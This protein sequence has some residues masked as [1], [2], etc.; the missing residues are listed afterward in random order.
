MLS[1]VGPALQLDGG[2]RPR[3]AS[4]YTMSQRLRTLLIRFIA[5]FRRYPGYGGKRGWR[6]LRRRYA[7]GSLRLGPLRPRHG[8]GRG[9][10]RRVNRRR[11]AFVG[12]TMAQPPSEPST[13]DAGAQ[14]EGPP[15]LYRAMNTPEVPGG[16]TPELRGT[17]ELDGSDAPQGPGRWRPRPDRHRMRGRDGIREKRSRSFKP[18]R[19]HPYYDHD[20]A[21]LDQMRVHR[22]YADP[23]PSIPEDLYGQPEDMKPTIKTEGKQE[24]TAPAFAPATRVPDPLPPAAD[25]DAPATQA[26]N[27]QMDAPGNKAPESQPAMLPLESVP[28]PRTSEIPADLAMPQDTPQPATTPD[29]P[30]G[31]ASTPRSSD[32]PRSLTP[33]RGASV[34]A[35]APPSSAP[36]TSSPL[37]EGLKTPLPASS[38]SIEVPVSDLSS[39]PPSHSAEHESANVMIS[40]HESLAKSADTASEERDDELRKATQALAQQMLLRYPLSEQH[41]Q[42]LKQ[43]NQAIVHS[44]SVPASLAETKAAAPPIQADPTT[45]HTLIHAQIQA[46]ER[47]YETKLQALRTEYR[48]KHQAWTEYCHKLDQMYERRVQRNSMSASD[49]A[50]MS[51]SLSSVLG[52]PVSSRSFRRGGI[53]AGGF[54][55][56]VRSEAEFQEIL[57]SLEN[58]EMQDPAVRAARTSATVPDMDLR[59]P[60][61]LDNDNGYVADP[62]R[63][64]FHSFDPDV[65]SE[66]EKAIF[67][68]RYVLYPK[69]F[70]RIAEKLPHKTAKQ[71]VAF[72]YLHKHLEGYKALLHARHR[73]RRKKTKSRPSKSKGSALMADIAATDA[74]VMDEEKHATP[75]RRSEDATPKPKRAKT[76]PKPKREAAE[77]ERPV[78]EPETA[79]ERDLAA[80]EALEA[81]AGLA[82]PARVEP[83]KRK[84]RSKEGEEPKSRSRGPH[85]SM[86]ERAEFL[87][88]LATYGKDWHA[89]SASFP[90]KTPAQTRNFFAR[91]ASE[92]EHFQEA[93]A[94]AQKHAHLS[95]DDK[96][97]AAVAF[98]QQW[99]EALPEGAVKAS[100]TGW[101]A[102]GH[103]PPPPPPKEPVPPIQEAAPA[104][105]DETDEE[106]RSAG[107]P[108]AT[109]VPSVPPMPQPTP[110]PAPVT[111]STTHAPVPP[112]APPSRSAHPAHSEPSWTPMRSP[113]PPMMYSSSPAYQ[114]VPQGSVPM[115]Y[116]DPS[117]YTPPV[118]PMGL[119]NYPLPKYGMPADPHARYA[120]EATYPANS[121]LSRVPMRP[122]PN[123]GYFHAR[124]ERWP[125]S[126]SRY[127]PP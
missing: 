122:A 24:V 41:V 110:A 91:H 17:T 125:G 95:W 99:Y 88:L 80:A 40:S 124:P 67:A 26:Q 127:P 56:V 7:T 100:I 89:L 20:R 14:N 123:M 93:A 19:D 87:R 54:G 105:D 9:S 111:T 25:A 35:P 46:K 75:K 51:G 45:V 55:D 47:A 85:W 102:P 52:T 126:D 77:S 6:I 11:T 43:E 30:M 2:S 104:D 32:G 23:A 118:P 58:A 69:Q 61:V 44:L 59:E 42:Q 63:F 108:S 90:A 109:P 92:S 73:E 84:S 4:S 28:E 21:G 39:L 53:G 94:L 50:P 114:S 5:I 106:D 68:R 27:L 72:Y 66:E 13:N 121:P 1:P 34:E 103:A 86:T 79:S 116:R 22:P 98:V 70:G 18:M 112:S 37:A 64:Y 119:Y 113:M 81:L 57:A 96:A 36:L 97:Q 65:W 83:K 74:E 38:L 48:K 3:S 60:R 62:V 76:A 78:T 8:R 107:P 71:C 115:Y 29:V 82:T 33:P 31:S 120:P 101:P 10:F 15:P 49:E 16:A 12:R 117:A